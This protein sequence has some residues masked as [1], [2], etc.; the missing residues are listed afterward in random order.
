MITH[1]QHNV[2]LSPFR[3]HRRV[4]N[5]LENY[6]R[7]SVAFLGPTLIAQDLGLSSWNIPHFFVT[8]SR[9]CAYVRL[10]SMP[11]PSTSQN[12]KESS[13]PGHQRYLFRTRCEI[14][15]TDGDIARICI[16]TAASFKATHASLYCF[17]VNEMIYVYQ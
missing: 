16:I 9:V 8:C 14:Q 15:I 12:R 5:Y 2:L 4:N 11:L 7:H 6:A 13:P 3:T 1:G 10:I 17:S